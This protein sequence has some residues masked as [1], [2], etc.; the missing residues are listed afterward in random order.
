VIG[1][2][3]GC[4]DTVDRDLLFWMVVPQHRCLSRTIQG[5]LV[6]EL[7]FKDV[8]LT[9]SYI[10]LISASLSR[11]IV[12]L[13]AFAIGSGL[14][15]VGY[16]MLIDEMSM[17]IWEGLF[18]T[19]NAVQLTMLLLEQR[20]ARLTTEEENLRRA[21]FNQ[22]S[23]VDFHRMLR[24][25]TWVSV[26]AGAVLTTQGM[27]VVRIVLVTDGAAQVDID[28]KIVAY[29]RRGDFIGEMAFVSGNPASATVTSIGPMRYLMWRF[30]DL[31]DLLEKH[32]DIRSALQ[33][34]FNRNLI[35]KLAREGA[36][37]VPS[38]TP[39]V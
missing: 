30:D 23:V 10:L 28:G 37:E 20:R 12:P 2:G 9:V 22:L 36:V 16:A 39:N 32:P 14:M 35:E 34:V 26:E 1:D 38:G 7:G 27:P 18:A 29:C 19:T 21:M 4:K 6:G 31:R 13:R 17:W 25:G 5:R 24:T 33:S 3:V 11:K 8:L 15:A